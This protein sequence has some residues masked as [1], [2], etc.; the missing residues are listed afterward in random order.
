MLS[1]RCCGGGVVWCGVIMVM[2]VLW[3]CCGGGV[4]WCDYS[5]GGAVVVL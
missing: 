3:W 1:P 4:V 5:G 2:V